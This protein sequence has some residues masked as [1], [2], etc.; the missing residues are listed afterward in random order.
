MVKVV[1]T[2]NGRLV[3]GSVV[4]LR[5]GRVI[6]WAEVRW[7]EEGKP[8]GYG[9]KLGEFKRGECRLTGRGIRPKADHKKRISLKPNQQARVRKTDRK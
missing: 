5:K 3:E 6:L 1:D 4:E 9:R 2:R 7:D 8:H